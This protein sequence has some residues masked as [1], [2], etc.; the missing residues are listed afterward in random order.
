MEWIKPLHA[1]FWGD[2]IWIYISVKRR[3][4]CFI[5]SSVEIIEQ[6]EDSVQPVY[7]Y[8]VMDTGS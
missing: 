2:R 5:F 6:L 3:V 8:E 4:A 7:S 1:A